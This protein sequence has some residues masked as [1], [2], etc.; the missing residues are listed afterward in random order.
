MRKPSRTAG[1]LACL[2]LAVAGASVVAACSSG[3]S[4]PGTSAPAGTSPPTTSEAAPTEAEATDGTPAQTQPAETGGTA[5]AGPGEAAE[6]S[7][8]DAPRPGSVQGIACAWIAEADPAV[9]ARMSERLLG[10]L[11][12]ASG[13]A[14]RS[15]CESVIGGLTPAGDAGLVTFADPERRGKRTTLVL[16]DG[17]QDIV[18]AFEFVRSGGRWAIDE[19][20]QLS[21]AG[22]EDSGGTAE[23][24]TP[25]SA[26]DDGEIAAL[27]TR[28]YADVDPGVCDSMTSKMLQFGWGA[29]GSK[30]RGL[31]EQSLA[32]A[33]P[34]GDVVVRK[35]SI[36]GDEATAEVVY[37]LDGDRQIDEISLIRVNGAWLV[38]SVRLAGFAS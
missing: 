9:C 27:V 37:T 17:N 2:T 13:S 21:N 22:A 35:P 25:K 36:D 34:V 32:K 30:G 23:T 33:D 16:A 10:E 24:V 28:W 29:K 15:Q 4:A 12:G 6:A 20:Q 7:C 1:R 26:G 5:E 19:V 14:A 31:C 18:Y 3:G 8:A 11:F 38:D